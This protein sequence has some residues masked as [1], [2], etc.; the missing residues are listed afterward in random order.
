MK[1]K[2]TIYEEGAAWFLPRERQLVCLDIYLDPSQSAVSGSSLLT[3]E[4]FLN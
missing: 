1:F 3:H 2:H 4:W